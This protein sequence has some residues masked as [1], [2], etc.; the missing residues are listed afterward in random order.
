MTKSN[1]LIRN[2]LNYGDVVLCE[3]NGVLFVAKEYDAMKFDFKVIHES[4]M[5]PHGEVPEFAHE[6]AIHL[7][8]EGRLN[9]Y[10]VYAVNKSSIR[11]LCS[12]LSEKLECRAAVTSYARVL[13]AWENG[14]VALQPRKLSHYYSDVP[15]E[16]DEACSF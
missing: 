7:T 9:D 11:A 6:L 13:G 15:Q 14:K 1:A 4:S 2:G 5:L 8:Y 3:L 12:Y 10:T 16:Q